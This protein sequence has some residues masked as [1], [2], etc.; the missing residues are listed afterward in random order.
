MRLYIETISKLPKPQQAMTPFEFKVPVDCGEDTLV[1]RHTNEVPSEYYIKK[2]ATKGYCFDKFIMLA[3]NECFSFKYK[4]RTPGSDRT[5]EIETIKYH[6]KCL[7]EYIRDTDL[8]DNPEEYVETHTL[9]ISINNT[10]IT[11]DFQKI[12]Q[13]IV[14][15]SNDKNEPIEI[16]M[17]FTGGSRVT[18]MTLLLITRILESTGAEV[19]QVIYGNINQDTKSIDDATKSYNLLK[20]VEEIAGAKEDNDY[21]LQKIFSILEENNLDHFDEATKIAAKEIDDIGMSQASTIKSQSEEIIQSYEKKMSDFSS[22]IKGTAQGFSRQIQSKTIQKSKASSF[23]KL[24]QKKDKELIM[25]FHEELTDVFIEKAIIVPDDNN[26]TL[27]IKNFK[28]LLKDGMY[29]YQHTQGESDYGVLSTIK[30]WLEVLKSDLNKN[31]I[32]L[33]NERLDFMN[34]FYKQNP[35]R[36]INPV[37]TW[38]NQ[39][40][41][42]LIFDRNVYIEGDDE[43]SLIIEF[44]R[45]QNIYFSYGFPFMCTNQRGYTHKEIMNHYRELSKKVMRDLQTQK[46][47][48]KAAYASRIDQLLQNDSELAKVIPY[49][50]VGA[51]V[52]KVRDPEKFIKEYLDRLEEV[53]PVRNIIAHNGIPDKQKETV[54]KIR[55][56]I[57]EYGQMPELK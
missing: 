29:Y 34:D 23:D 43:K 25:K 55:K 19:K 44:F 57:H 49:Y 31:P 4:D 11:D 35:P 18:A 32:D 7:A 3:T 52:E 22:R 6:K 15:R 20:A 40:F 1:G 27:S 17:D 48:N 41:C 30:S 13:N 12:Y 54:A 10:M 56:W 45:I 46:D 42:K 26:S 36:C 24:L 16:Y 37:T 50:A 5:E 51:K 8:I 39:S 47:Q 9:I 21:A 28:T 53:R 14:V 38:S 33:F 2:L